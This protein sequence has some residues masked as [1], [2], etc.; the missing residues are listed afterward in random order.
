[1]KN[2]SNQTYRNL[3]QDRFISETDLGVKIYEL[4]AAVLADIAEELP[5]DILIGACTALI[6]QIEAGSRPELY[7]ALVEQGQ[8]MDSATAL[9][10]GICHF[11]SK[12]NILARLKADLGSHHPFELQRRTYATAEYE[13]WKPLGIQVHIVPGNALQVPVLSLLEGLM[14]GNI[15]VLKNT[16]RNGCF[17]GLFMKALI[18]SD[19][20]GILK[21]FVYVF[22]IPSANTAWINELTKLAD[23]VCVWGG[24]EAVK[25]VKQSCAAHVRVVAWGHKISFAYFDRGSAANR[26]AIAALAADICK[27]NQQA[28][29]SPQCVLVEVESEE[30]LEAF[31][32]LLD[33]ALQSATEQYPLQL[34]SMAE[35]AEIT[36]AVHLHQATIAEKGGKVHQP[37]DHSYRVLIDH[38]SSLQPSP[39][40]RT[41]WVKP[42]KRREII[43][44]L[45]PFNLYLQTC[46]L[47]SSDLK[48]AYEISDLLLK[49]GVQRITEM[50]KQHESY[51]GEPHD[52]VYALQQYTKRVAVRLGESMTAGL[53]SLS[54][55]A[56]HTA[57]NSQTAV[58]I[59]TKE[60]RQQERHTAA[61]LFLKSG[62]SSGQTKVA[63]YSW[64]DWDAQIKIMADSYF[65]GGIR[66][67]DCCANMYSAG[68]LYG[69]FIATQKALEQLGAATLAL[70]AH[71]DTQTLAENII[72]LQPNV[73]MGMP[74]LLRKL[75][76]EQ[77][78]LLRTYKGFEKLVYGGELMSDAQQQWFKSEFGFQSIFSP[79]YASNDALMNGYACQHCNNG[80]FHV[81]TRVLEVEIVAMNSAEPVRDREV[82]RLLITK[83]SIRDPELKRY[84]IGDLAQW[85]TTPCPCGHRTPKFRL[86]GRH[87]DLIRCG[88]KFINYRVIHQILTQHAKYGDEVQLLIT[89]ST[90]EAD[91]I[92]LRLLDTL[93]LDAQ[94]V[95][96]L[97]LEHYADLKWAV[98]QRNVQLHIEI[99]STAIFEIAPASG[100]VR[101]LI[102]LRTQD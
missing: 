67:T 59:T 43:G 13:A 40:F 44:V 100:K 25:N 51:I 58:S 93:G 32:A 80:E 64:E 99:G 33:V 78:A 48:S 46:G 19:V 6:A 63:G 82:G 24:E 30:Q 86:M 54:Y 96:Q 87:G 102:D 36:T 42:I 12:E 52:A 16:A 88:A 5:T 60:Q 91:C 28:C 55:L 98:E 10:R 7:R 73:I 92:T 53:P 83:K 84:D 77:H 21:K 34:P 85:V 72:L 79:V 3:W 26:E 15:N 49:A 81:P 22:E 97:L 65:I 31:G 9:V 18:D 29:T 56:P 57:V 95:S 45:R 47:A 71:L 39:L 66:A 20:T 27:R 94:R 75:F 90:A 2:P 35:Q 4:G 62:G 23:V 37:A 101:T 50:G 14:A 69:G 68:N 70:G 41:I 76:R 38:R 8:S 74:S 17:T 11:M 61:K 89:S 1:M